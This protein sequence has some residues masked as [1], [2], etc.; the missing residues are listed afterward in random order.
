MPEKKN[1]SRDALR[2]AAVRSAKASASLEGRVVPAV[3]VELTAS[4]VSHLLDALFYMGA[5]QGELVRVA[6][7]AVKLE[8]AERLLNE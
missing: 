3:A 2:R 1:V 5:E 7:I 8:E 6:R 4:E